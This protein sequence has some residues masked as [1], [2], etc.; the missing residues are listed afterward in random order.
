MVSTLEQSDLVSGLGLQPG[1]ANFELIPLT[2]EGAIERAQLAEC[3]LVLLD[4]KQSVE[5]TFAYLGGFEED[6]GQSPLWWPNRV[7][8]E[9][10]QIDAFWQRQVLAQP[11]SHVGLAASDL[12]TDV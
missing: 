12:L 10:A 3:F 4:L 6:R 7:E 5:L 1:G 11:P 9:R 2:V 8:K